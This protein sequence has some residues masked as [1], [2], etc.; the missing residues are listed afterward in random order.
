MAPLI[1]AIPVDGTANLLR[2]GSPHSTL[3][4]V[5]FEACRIEGNADEIEHAPDLALRILDQPFVDDAVDCAGLDLVEMCHEP[6][7]IAV[8]RS[9]RF[10]AVSEVNAASVILLEVR[11]PASHG[12]A[13]RVDD[14]RVRQGQPNQADVHPIGRQLV[15]E[16]RLGGCP[17]GA[18]A[19]DIL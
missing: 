10:L 17:E 3:V 5:E 9:D 8:E 1:N 7:I 18:A 4:L 12:M 2:A 14:L 13:A 6:P 15:D 11:K 19:I 16:E